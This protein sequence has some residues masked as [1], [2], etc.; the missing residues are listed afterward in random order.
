MWPGSVYTEKF[1]GTKEKWKETY[2]THWYLLTL[3]TV[4]FYGDFFLL[5][6]V[7]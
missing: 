6:D 1:K 2:Q 4:Y 7:N 5:T 3:S